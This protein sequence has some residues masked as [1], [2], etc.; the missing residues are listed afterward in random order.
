MMARRWLIL[1]GLLMLL[2]GGQARADTCSVAASNVTF[3]SVSSISSSDVYTSATFTVTCTWTDVLTNLLT[4]NVTVCLTLGA[5][6]N[7]SSSVTAPRQ[8]GNGAVVANYNLYADSSYSAAKIWGG[9]LGTSTATQPI[10]ITM[11]KSGGVGSLSTPVTIYGKLTADATLAANSVGST[12]VTA[13][14]SFGG[15]SAAMNYQF[16][17]LG[18]L[19]CVL[20]QAVAMPFVVSAPIVNDCNINIANMV[21]PTSSLLTGTLTSSAGMSVRC[22]KDTAYRIVLSGGANS[23]SA[24][25]RKMK[26]V[27]GT[28]TVDYALLD[29]PGGSVWGDGNGG[30]VVVSGTGDGTTVTRSVYGRVPSQST[31]S[32]GDYKDTIMATVQF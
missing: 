7:S 12:D 27:S 24:L 2:L 10:I 8:L 19:G 3:P 15:G 11:V 14:S 31:P 5:G 30:T 28:E 1:L 18:L 25:T 16:S 21:F 17:V 6:T 22:S 29:A 23:G 26:K 20:P 32:P 13:T 9:W 4:P